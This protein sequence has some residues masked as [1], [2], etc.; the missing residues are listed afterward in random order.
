MAAGKPAEKCY[1]SC[2]KII[3]LANRISL[4]DTE[5][6]PLLLPLLGSADRFV[7]PSVRPSTARAR[8][9]VRVCLAVDEQKKPLTFYREH[10]QMEPRNG[11]MPRGRFGDISQ[12]A[13]IT[14][15]KTTS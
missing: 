11:G 2:Q 8:A 9:R 5:S 3:F 13:S 12:Y 15:A 7:R 6:L 1:L 14:D 4:C 10:R